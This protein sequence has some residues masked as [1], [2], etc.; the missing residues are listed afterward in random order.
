MIKEINVNLNVFA[1]IQFN[2]MKIHFLV[3]CLR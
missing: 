3:L 1:S 2:S